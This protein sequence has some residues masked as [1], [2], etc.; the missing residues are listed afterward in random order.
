MPLPPNLLELLFQMAQRQRRMPTRASSLFPRTAPP[1]RS[2]TIRGGMQGP[3]PMGQHPALRAGVTSPGF[4]PI[5]GTPRST[6][7]QRGPEPASSLQQFL[8]AAS[9]AV[10]MTGLAGSLA[11]RG[12]A[13]I[14]SEALGGLQGAGGLINILS[15]LTAPEQV[16]TASRVLQGISG[17]TQVLQGAAALPGAENIPGLQQ[18]SQF[19][20]SDIPGLGG[21]AAG[22]VGGVGTAGWDALQAA[23]ER[24]VASADMFG[25]AG[26]QLVSGGAASGLTGLM[27]GVGGLL[28]SA[29]SAAQAFTGPEKDQGK[30]FML[31]G[32]SLVPGGAPVTAFAKLM[33]F[34][35]S[36]DNR[37]PSA[38][39]RRDQEVRAS[40]INAAEAL[41]NTTGFEGV[42]QTLLRHTGGGAGAPS[43]AEL[44]ADPSGVI[45]RLFSDTAMFGEDLGGSGT[46][47]AKINLIEALARGMP[48]V[49]AENEF[50]SPRRVADSALFS[51]RPGGMVYDKRTGA[52][53]PEADARAR[54]RLGD[55][56]MSSDLLG[57]LPPSV[58]ALHPDVRDATAAGMTVPEWLASQGPRHVEGGGFEGLPTGRYST[59]GG[60][61][62]WDAETGG[63]EPIHSWDAFA[64]GL[65]QGL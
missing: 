32:M 19:S 15:A 37:K 20:Q 1:I 9:P 17:G 22:A 11:A 2:T 12:G 7:A 3:S 18:V 65:G 23:L 63:L 57:R 4:G 26:S 64:G 53:I 42:A 52:M 30:N 28:S 21:A 24:S 51:P 38:Q 49:M 16:P 36:L 34:L 46:R 47:M 14:P 61:V 31:S 10:G 59:P 6:L 5:P 56:D 48:P 8:R 58:R 29:I 54:Y 40:Q 44:R 25:Q 33:E 55:F 27:P 13:P 43:A 60:L 50:F 45:G 35:T 39:S 62:S 41:R